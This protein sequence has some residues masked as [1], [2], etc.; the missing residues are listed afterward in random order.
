KRGIVNREV[1]ECDP[2]LTAFLM[3]KMYIALI[4]DWEKAHESL[5][6]EEI[7]NHLE[8]YMMSGIKA[9]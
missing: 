2:S 8:F 5:G 7:A 4:F 1:K 6:K 9:E 3:F